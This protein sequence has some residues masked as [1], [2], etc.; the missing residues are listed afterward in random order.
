MIKLSNISRRKFTKNVAIGAIGLPLG[1]TILHRKKADKKL[2]I[3]LVGLGRY[4]GLLAEGIELSKYCEL[5]GIVTGTPSK[6]VEWG[7]KYHL[8]A[9]GIYNY[10]TFDRI[11]EN[12]N[13]DVIYIVLPNGMHKEYALRA[14][15]AGKHVIVEKPL[16]TNAAD[17]LDIIHGCEKA[18]VQLAVGYRLHYEP[19]NMEMMRLGQKKIY[20]KVRLVEAELGYNMTD[21]NP[22]DWHFNKKLSGGGS[23]QNLG[24]YCVQAARYILGEEPTAV[25]A[26]FGPNSKPELFKEVE[27]SVH[28]KLEFASGTL[29]HSTCSAAYPLDRLFAS[30]ERNTFELSPAISYGPFRG[31]TRDGEFKFPQTNMQQV[32]LD[33]MAKVLLAGEKFPM[34]VSGWEGYKDL[35][36]M[37]AIYKSAENETRVLI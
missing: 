14:A 15:K 29:A 32:Q 25:T 23:L 22:N 16:A 20:G 17:C 8:P 11:A 10:E 1:Y 33:E 7:K 30:A 31:W 2:R 9:S 37:D 34:H 35:K 28:W 5:T 13:I 24:V 18:G 4:A 21:M 12:K 3:A 36:V 6:V 26:Y 19:Y 27:E